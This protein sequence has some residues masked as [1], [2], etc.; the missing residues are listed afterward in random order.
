M[1]SF[2]FLMA[3]GGSA[4]GGIN[5]YHSQNEIKNQVCQ[6]ASNINSY[7]NSMAQLLNS[8]ILEESQLQSKCTQE[9]IKIVQNQ[10]LIRDLQVEFKKTY[11]TWTV[12]ASVFMVFLIFIFACKK[13]LLGS[14]TEIPQKFLNPS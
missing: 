5:A 14:T 7:N 12:I 1:A 4:S 9:K 11:T 13:Y 10:A 8:D 2:L 3:C 6:M